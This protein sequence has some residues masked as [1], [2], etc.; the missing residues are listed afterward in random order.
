MRRE[1]AAAAAVVFG[2]GPVLLFLAL[3]PLHGRTAVKYFDENVFVPVDHAF[4][5]HVRHRD[6]AEL[7]SWR[8]QASPGVDSF[9]RVFRARPV[10]PA[11]DPTLPPGRDGIRCLSPRSFAHNRAADCRLEMRFVGSSRSHTFVDRPP[12]GPW[13]YRVGLTANWRD[14][15]AAG[16]VLLLSAPAG[17]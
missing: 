10:A 2:L 12:P 9:Y 7:L 16:D 8:A 11:P 4:S 5:V 6:G 14:D 1:A 13:V 3:S 15:T 17:R